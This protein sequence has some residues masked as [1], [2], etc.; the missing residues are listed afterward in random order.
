MKNTNNHLSDFFPLP[1]SKPLIKIL[2]F[3]DSLS[4]SFML[5]FAI[6]CF[7]KFCIIF[8]PLSFLSLSPLIID[9][10]NRFR[11][12]WLTFILKFIDRSNSYNLP[13]L[14]SG[15]WDGY[16]WR[17]RQSLNFWNST[18]IFPF[19]CYSWFRGTSWTRWC[20]TRPN[21]QLRKVK[22]TLDEFCNFLSILR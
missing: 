2:L 20:L 22:P 17:N 1:T 21:R 12:Y 16:F 13:V 18:K 19:W 7:L 11:L 9:S 4:I 8:C 14:S 5:L 15:L 10:S 6:T 3:L